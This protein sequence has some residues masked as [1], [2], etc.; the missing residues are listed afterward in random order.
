M[1]FGL[2]E[3]KATSDAEANADPAS[4]MAMAIK[5]MRAS[6]DKLIKLT[7]RGRGS[8]SNT[9]PIGAFFSMAFS[10]RAMLRGAY[11]DFVQNTATVK[12]VNTWVFT[13]VADLHDFVQCTSHVSV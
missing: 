2:S 3:K 13:Q 10:I 4:K 1:S 7:R 6:A 11:G 12:A 9:I 5:G 8:G